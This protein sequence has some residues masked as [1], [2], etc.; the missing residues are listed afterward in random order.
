M[1]EKQKDGGFFENVLMVAGGISGAI[2]GYNNGEF[3]G[4]IMGALILGGIGKWIG[5]LADAI[6]KIIFALIIILLNNA[7]RR[8][9]WDIIT[10]AF[11]G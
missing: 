3:I 9:F 7:V 5:S 11:A 10:S 2:F 6:F 4:L 1:G 8:F